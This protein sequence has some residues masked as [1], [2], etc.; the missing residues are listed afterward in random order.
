[1][2]DS[3]SREIRIWDS[4]SELLKSKA[5]TARVKGTTLLKRVAKDIPASYFFM[6]TRTSL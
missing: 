6:Y 2:G 3:D 5:L 4:L 1:M